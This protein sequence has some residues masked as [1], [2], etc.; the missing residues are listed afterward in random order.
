MKQVLLIQGGGQGTHEEWDNKILDS[1]ERELGP[2]YAVRYPRMPHEANPKYAAWK[3][4]TI[5]PS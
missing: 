1:V 3:A 4:T 5:R 2:D